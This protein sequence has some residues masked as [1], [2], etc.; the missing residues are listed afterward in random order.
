MDRSPTPIP[1]ETNL[2]YQTSYN[3]LCSIDEIDSE[4]GEVI[5]KYYTQKEDFNMLQPES[6]FS[7]IYMKHGDLKVSM[8]FPGHASDVDSKSTIHTSVCDKL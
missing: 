6:E 2:K 4:T 3:N 1:F 7:G 5:T 8:G